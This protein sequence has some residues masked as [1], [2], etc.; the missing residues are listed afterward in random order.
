MTQQ[1]SNV[2]DS[3]SD[4]FTKGEK[5][6]TKEI[7]ERL[8]NLETISLR[9]ESTQ[10]RIAEEQTWQR[11]IV[12]LGFLVTVIALVGVV[13]SLFNLIIDFYNY[14]NSYEQIQINLPT[15]L[16]VNLNK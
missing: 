14:K 8:S 7:P 4:S 10:D 3:L 11:N 16:N 13:L 1:I 15:E 12:Y 5:P 9:I 6:I 2:E